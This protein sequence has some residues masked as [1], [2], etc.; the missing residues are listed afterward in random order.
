[1]SKRIF[2][3]VLTILI[4]L[5]TPTVTSV[6]ADFPSQGPVWRELHYYYHD[7]EK[8]QWAGYKVKECNGE[9]IM[10]WGEETQYSDFGRVICD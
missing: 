2:A 5:T 1:M 9:V 4:C 10:Y 6:R 3:S 7:A 8:T